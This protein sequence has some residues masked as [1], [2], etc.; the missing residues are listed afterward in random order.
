[1]EIRD[2]YNENKE[3]TGETILKGE[4]VPKGRYYITVV[5]WIKND[6]GKF[7]MQKRLKRKIESAQQK[8]GIQYLK[9]LVSKEFLQ[10]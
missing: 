10:K 6:E 3:L 8:E 2:L 1:M 7:L 5:V 4:S 9:K